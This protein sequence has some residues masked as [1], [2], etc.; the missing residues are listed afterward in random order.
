MAAFLAATG[1]TLVQVMYDD[2]YAGAGLM[3]QVLAVGAWF[4]ILEC[5]NGSALLA[6][7]KP[8]WVAAGNTA[9]LV[10]L[11]VLIPAGFALGGFVGAIGGAVAADALKYVTAAAGVAVH[12]LGT[13][14]SD[15]FLTLMAAGGGG[16]LLMVGAGIR[17]AGGG[18][19][20]VLATSAGAVALFAGAAALWKLRRMGAVQPG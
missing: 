15:V 18:D 6:L 5:T 4:Q 9:K 19:A 3:L 12:G 8:R 1:T 20:A 11:V 2:R 10:A 7:G 16:A 13:I 14:I 17:R